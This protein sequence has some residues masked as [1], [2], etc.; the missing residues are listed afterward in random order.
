MFDVME[1][2]L[3]AA[4]MILWVGISFEQSASTSYFRRVRPIWTPVTSV[5][6]YARMQRP[7]PAAGWI[8]CLLPT[9]RCTVAARV[10]CEPTTCETQ[11]A[12]L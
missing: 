7:R 10:Q 8:G 12:A 9:H 1:D 6:C 3:A 4:D 11:I 2:D 5:P